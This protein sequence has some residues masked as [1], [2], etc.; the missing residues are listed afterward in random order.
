VEA[1]F[2]QSPFH[3][4]RSIDTSLDFCTRPTELQLSR[5]KARGRTYQQICD[6]TLLLPSSAAANG[7]GNGNGSS[8]S[9]S[10]TAGSGVMISYDAGTFLPTS[11]GSL[12]GSGS[13]T[14]A[15]SYGQAS[16]SAGRMIVDTVA[17]WS[18]GVNCALHSGVA[19][20]AVIGTLKTYAEQKSQQ[21]HDGSSTVDAASTSDADHNT[22]YL[23]ISSP[24]PDSLVGMTWPVVPGFSLN[25]R[26]WGVAMVHG[27]HPVQ[28]QEHAFESLVMSTQR[29]KLIKALVMSHEAKKSADV[30]AGKGEGSIFLLHGPPGV[31][32]TLTA[33]AISEMLHKPLYVVSMGELGTTPEALESRLQDILDLCIPWKALVLI[34]EA[35]MLL[36]ART[37]SDI[38]RNSMVCVMVRTMY[39]CLLCEILDLG[40]LCWSENL[41]FSALD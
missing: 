2:L 41:Q 32:K 38:L 22:E 21:Q 8:I 27:T 18:R 4:S 36:E 1:Q 37:K 9:S 16:R 3:G 5:L 34:D 35:E 24:L 28:F 17:A 23:I 20:D 12:G 14:R 40:R 11:R 31:G 25:A 6:G 30:I 15:G 33:E 39:V 10:G 13:S 29:K 26:T 19:S 7:N